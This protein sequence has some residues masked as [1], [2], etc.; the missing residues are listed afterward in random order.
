N[1]LRPF[2]HV[3]ATQRFP[4]VSL[5]A[6]GL[7]ALVACAFTLD[8]IINALIAGIV[9]VQPIAQ[10]AAVFVLRTRG[11]RAPYRTRWFPI[12]PVLAL[13]GWVWV[14]ISAGEAAIT[15]GLVS[16][17]VGALVYA[18]SHAAGGAG[19]QP[20]AQPRG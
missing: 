8:R 13:I 19:L 4:D 2:A 11:V 16:L 20:G 1:F 18:A 3:H 10:I 7:L 9:L 12:P 14:F 17:G 5:V 15:F 6:M